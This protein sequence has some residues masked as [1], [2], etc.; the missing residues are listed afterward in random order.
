MKNV[1]SSLHETE[2]NI[3]VGVEYTVTPGSRGTF[4]KMG[5]PIDPPEAPEVEI[6][7]VLVGD[8]ADCINLLP[9]LCDDVVASLATEI[10]DQLEDNV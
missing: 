3:D 5:A 6:T 9:K 4:D 1:K 10:A 7:A 2:I 8:G